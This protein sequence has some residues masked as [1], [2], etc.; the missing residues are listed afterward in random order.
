M[1]GL[2]LKYNKV[3]DDS[4]RNLAPK[5]AK[6]FEVLWGDLSTFGEEMDLLTYDAVKE[7]LV[8]FGELE[9]ILVGDVFWRTGQSIC[10]YGRER[11]I[12]VFF[13]Q[14]GQWIYVKNKKKLPYYPAYTLLLGDNV[15]NMCSSWTYGKNSHIVS[16]GSPRYDNASPN[17]GSYVYFSPPVIEELIHRKPT[18]KLRRSF[19]EN[20][21]AI[22]NI[23]KEL[24]IVIQPHYREARTDYLHQ[25]FPHAQF[26]DPQLDAL[27]LVRGAT[28]VLTSR[29]STVILDAIAHHKPV[30]LMD[31]P[32]YDACF[33]K[34]GYF[35]SLALE[36]ETKSHLAS[37]LLAEVKIKRSAYMNAREYIYL[38]NASDRIVESIKE[39]V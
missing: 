31:F 14:H 26:A 12:P 10:R 27:K 37:N 35:N 34:R 28:K 20:L 8:L 39:G 5:L 2:L 3:H 16:S 1:R 22:K 32:E 33:F 24:Q 9:F 6:Y 23:D 17:G 18:G 13:L 30:V 4:L 36:S 29:N 11:D 7:Y 15:A 19:Y 21:K 38:G 25:L